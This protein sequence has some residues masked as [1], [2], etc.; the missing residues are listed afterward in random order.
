MGVALGS[1]DGNPIKMDRDDY[2]TAT[3]VI[4]S[5]GKT[6]KKENKRQRDSADP[7]T[8]S[9]PRTTNQKA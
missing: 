2:C 8:I 4:N 3:N 5:L 7:D 6:K 1:R 9:N